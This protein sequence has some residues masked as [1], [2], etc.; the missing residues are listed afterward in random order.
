[1]Y[2]SRQPT[3]T[4][5]QRQ[6]NHAN[7][8]R[9][10]L[11]IVVFHPRMFWKK[12]FHS[13]EEAF[14]SLPRRQPNVFAYALH[15]PAAKVRIHRTVRLLRREE[16]PPLVAKIAQATE[17]EFIVDNARVEFLGEPRE[18]TTSR[19]ALRRL[20]SRSVAGLLGIP[21]GEPL[22]HLLENRRLLH[23]T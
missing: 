4:S 10:I 2:V 7:H 14:T 18:C 17:V 9:I 19:I 12:K 11:R 1:M 21:T 3:C 8:F 5:K 16:V 6:V 22:L 23:H 13:P 20:R 15:K